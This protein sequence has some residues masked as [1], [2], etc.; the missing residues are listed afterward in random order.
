MSD[1]AHSQ[2]MDGQRVSALHLQHL[3]DRLREAIADIRRSIGLDK[4]AWG[5]RATLEG[6]QVRVLPGVAFAKSGVRLSLDDIAQAALPA[7]GSPWRVVLRGQNGDIEDLRHNQAPTVITLTTQLAIESDNGD[8]DNSTIIIATVDGTGL[9]QN[10]DRFVATGYHSHSGEWRQDNMGRWHFDGP[11][12][13]GPPGPQG[14]AGAKGDKGDTGATGAAGATG[15]KG[16]KGDTGATGA[17]GAKGDKGDTGATGAAGAT[18]AKGDKGDAGATGATGAKGDKG[19]T[20]ATGAAGAAGAKGDKGDAGATGATGAKGDKGD[21]GAT[22]AAGATGAKGDKGDAGATGATGAKGDKGDTGA[23]GATGAK[24]DKG[25]TG[26][27]GQP[28]QGLDP[29]W[30]AITKISWGHGLTVSPAQAVETIKQLQIQLSSPLSP[31]IREIKPQVVQVLFEYASRVDSTSALMPLV[32]IGGSTE[33]EQDLV[34]WT[35]GVGARELLSGISAG[36]RIWIRV[37]C[38]AMIDE[39]N[40]PFSASSDVLHGTHTPHAPGGVFES[41]YFVKSALLR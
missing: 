32:S 14:A 31:L 23:R 30:P 28:G 26:A 36:G 37:H 38:G 21:T 22:G 24:G 27:P 5:L 19:D 16:D 10:P 6:G 8:V 9:T 1:D 20:G 40:R 33:L 41:W 25:D 2:F 15:A 7:D 13:D 39:A 35:L 17:T 4:I 3:Q 12:L 18:G 29:D 34:V 11:A